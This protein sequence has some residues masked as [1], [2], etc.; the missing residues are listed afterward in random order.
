MVQGQHAQKDPKTPYQPRAGTVAMCL[1]SQAVQ[2][3]EI[4][5]IEVPGQP[6]QKTR[7]YLQNKQRKKGWKCGPRSRSPALQVQSPEFFS[8]TTKKK[9]KEQ[10]RKCCRS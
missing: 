2:E 9:K 10:I 8:L 7:P 5:R 3:I 6:G 1:T 4:W